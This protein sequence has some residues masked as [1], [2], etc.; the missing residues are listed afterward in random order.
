MN[1]MS[2]KE[3]KHFER[4][5]TLHIK[6]ADFELIGQ[7]YRDRDLYEYLFIKKSKP[8]HTATGKT[9][10]LYEIISEDKDPDEALKI[11]GD[12]FTEDDINILLRGGFHDDNK[13][14]EGV[15]EL[16]QH[17]LLAGEVLHPGG[18]AIEPQSFKDY[19]ERIQAYADQLINDDSID[20]LESITRVIGKAHYGDEKAVKLLLLSI[21]TL[22]LRDTP[23]VHQALRGSTGSGKTDLVLKTV[24]AVPERYVHILRSAS[25]K[26]LFYASETGI[27]RE[28]YNIFVFDD[29][30]LND[31]II[32]ISKTITDN[33]LPEKEHHTVKDQE[34]LKLEIPG[35]GLA[36]FTRARDI[37][38]NELND[39]LLYNNPVEDEDHSRF[40]KEKI[41]EEAISGSVMDDKRIME[42]YEVIRAV[43]ERLI[44]GDVRV[45]NPYLHLLDLRGYSN[46]DIKHIVGLVK[47]V[48]WYRQHKRMREGSYV[49]EGGHDIIIGTEDDLRD[50]LELWM[51]IDTLQRYKL[52]RKQEKFLKSL[53]EYSDELYKQHTDSIFEDDPELPTYRGLA[54]R[55]GL[56]KS[57]I[58]RWVKGRH[59]KD[60]DI[61]GLEDKGLVTIK[62]L[63]P[64]NPKSPSLIYLTP[65]IVG[66]H[67]QLKNGGEPSESGFTL[68][69][70]VDMDL[71]TAENVRIWKKT[72][73][74]SM[75]L[76]VSQ[77]QSNIQD[78]LIQ[79]W[80]DNNTNPMETHEDVVEFIVD[81]RVFIHDNMQ[82][83]P[84]VTCNPVYTILGNGK[85]PLETGGE[86]SN[87]GDKHDLVL[88]RAGSIVGN[89][90]N[91]ENKGSEPSDE[92]TCFP[93]KNY[94][95]G[96]GGDLRDEYMDAMARG[97]DS[98]IGELEARIPPDTPENLEERRVTLKKKLKDKS[99]SAGE[100]L[101]LLEELGG[102]LST[103]MRKPVDNERIVEYAKELGEVRREIED[104]QGG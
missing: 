20:I 19:P 51:S 75:F 26:Y 102:V 69:P 23:P 78:N 2:K 97:D 18:D 48:T 16:I 12:T 6:H 7:K 62:P 34:A 65:G 53:P 21:G 79:E 59:D 104:M 67:P 25:P 11:I 5:I 54:E 63:E 64:E 9:S 47:A 4:S 55:L 44:E 70:S 88:T 3:Y 24:L 13:T 32:A 74:H 30:E 81:V 61:E 90:V 49:R 10:N 71:G 99:I 46:R 93:Q 85:H 14:P 101:E 52:D 73:F 57:T 94:Y 17:I 86:S 37:H 15:L 40:V 33:I 42:A 41:K 87:H 72:I 50:A 31:E 1:S 56:S 29:I 28:D 8:I 80:L 38:D 98:M 27:L 39:R 35:E 89:R 66:K 96:V 45:Y 22:F 92:M 43:Y 58:Y 77:I 76:G 100:K 36:I 82:A 60:R 91:S 68:F 103:L 83:L 84:D 95:S